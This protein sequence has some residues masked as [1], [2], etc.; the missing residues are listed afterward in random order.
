MVSV[1]KLEKMLRPFWIGGGASSEFTDY[2]EYRRDS[3]TVRIDGYFE[4]PYRAQLENA[5]KELG[6]MK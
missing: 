2:E 6:L 3:K 4:I 1:R 5:V